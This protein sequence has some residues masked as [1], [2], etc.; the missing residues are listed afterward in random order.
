MLQLRWDYSQGDTG[1][2]GRAQGPRCSG[3]QS[4]PARAEQKNDH[5]SRLLA[6]SLLKCYIYAKFVSNFHQQN[7]PAA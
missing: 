7:P 1:D 3:R 5:H 4:S 2:S 6:E